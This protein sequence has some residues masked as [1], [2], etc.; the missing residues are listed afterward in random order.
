MKPLFAVLLFLTAG[1]LCADGT[2]YIRGETYA[3]GSSRPYTLQANSCLGFHFTVAEPYYQGPEPEYSRGPFMIAAE[4]GMQSYRIVMFE[5]DADS[6][7]I[8]HAVAE[9]DE[10][11]DAMEQ[12]FEC[13]QC[14]DGNWYWKLEL[15]NEW[16]IPS[17]VISRD[18]NERLNLIVDDLQVNLPEG[19]QR[20]TK[21]PEPVGTM[22]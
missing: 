16:G 5:S 20:V 8:F 18:C 12:K 4:Y 22:E 15:V 11:F 19:V 10:R 2:N 14:M 21:R 13:Y 3:T 7:V 1:S 9:I 6:T 17:A